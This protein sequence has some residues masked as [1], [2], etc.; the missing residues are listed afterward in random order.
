M[1]PAEVMAA[2]A[3]AGATTSPHL[4]KGPSRVI[5]DL[6]AYQVRVG[7]VE[8]VGPAL[9]AAVPER[10]SRSTRQRCLGWRRQFEQRVADD[11]AWLA[12]HPEEVGEVGE[13]EPTP[14]P[15]C[16]SPPP[17]D[18]HDA[19]GRQRADPPVCPG[20]PLSDAQQHGR[21]ASERGGLGATTAAASTA[22]PIVTA[23]VASEGG[24][25]DETSDARQRT[26]G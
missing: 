21:D 14:A 17:S 11:E 2:L 10:I 9:F 20:P 7:K 19:A 1:S 25:L 15:V 4:T 23:G 24:G 13:A 8:K 22:A 5:A 6:L 3:A 18:A 26:V 12:E 16:P